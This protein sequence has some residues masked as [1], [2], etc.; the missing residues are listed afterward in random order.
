MSASANEEGE[1][2][3]D[4]GSDEGGDCD[5]D[6]DHS[7]HEPTPGD[8]RL[9]FL[10]RGPYCAGNDGSSIQFN[11]I[12]SSTV[13]FSS[14]DFSWHLAHCNQSKFHSLRGKC[15]WGWRRA[16]LKSQHDETLICCFQEW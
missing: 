9:T 13:W 15:L 11:Y 4:D 12:L 16:V 2:D 5:D 1:V 10:R 14:G 7:H 8:A 3:D 6:D